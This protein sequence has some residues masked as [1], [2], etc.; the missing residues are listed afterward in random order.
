[1]LSHLLFTGNRLKEIIVLRFV[2]LSLDILFWFYLDCLYYYFNSLN[3]TDALKGKNLR[4]N[5]ETKNWSILNL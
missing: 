5:I 2:Y 1:M 4:N 3:S